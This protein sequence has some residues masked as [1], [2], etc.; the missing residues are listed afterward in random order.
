MRVRVLVIITAE[1]TCYV[2]AKAGN[3]IEINEK[4]ENTIN[5]RVKWHRV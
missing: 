1:V 2:R 3:E 4:E 5:R